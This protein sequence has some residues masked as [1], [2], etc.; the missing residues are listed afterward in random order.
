VDLTEVAVTRNISPGPT[1]V[2]RSAT[3]V[4]WDVLLGGQT[5]AAQRLARPAWAL[6][7]I[8]LFLPNL[9]QRT[10]SRVR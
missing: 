4:T 10:R 2:E 5:I 8:K 9:P 1:P 3:P 6:R 7:R